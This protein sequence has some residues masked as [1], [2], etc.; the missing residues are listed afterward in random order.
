MKLINQLELYSRNAMPA[1]EM[2]EIDDSLLQ[3]S[4]GYTKRAN[5]VIPYTNSIHKVESFVSDCEDFYQ[6]KERPTIF[7]MIDHHSY[8]D[9]AE[10][11][12]KNG[13]TKHSPSLVKQ[14]NLCELPLLKKQKYGQYV[15]K[16]I[17]IEGLLKLH[18]ISS[19]DVK[20]LNM[21]VEKQRKKQVFVQ[22]V[23]DG[24]LLS[25]GTAILDH[26]HVGLFHIITKEE[27]RG[28]GFAKQLVQQLLTWGK[29]NGAKNAYLQV[30]KENEAAVKLYNHFGFSNVFEYYYFIKS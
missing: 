9:L 23:E 15:T 20:Y 25:S 30:L 11:L 21:M 6:K 19:K 7:K 5:S 16:D 2:K 4:Y 1:L 22:L 29:Q 14:A 27:R 26:Q 17:W 10:F 12:E 8:H 13:Y 28:E 24:E 3:Y 18:S